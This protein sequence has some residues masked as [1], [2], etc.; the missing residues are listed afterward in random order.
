METEH[1][2]FFLIA[3]IWNYSETVPQNTNIFLLAKSTLQI[4]H[5]PMF[6]VK[7][8]ILYIVFWK[9]GKQKIRSYFS[10]AES[11]SCMNHSPSLIHL[12]AFLPS[13]TGSAFYKDKVI[14]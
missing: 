8:L 7:I 5:R 11:K 3:E 6:K 13:Q 10:T 9:P 14:G 4:K 1:V 12:L 2:L